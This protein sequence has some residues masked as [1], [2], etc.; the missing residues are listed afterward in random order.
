M[1][2]DDVRKQACRELAERL[3]TP[4][5]LRTA[6]LLQRA[7]LL[8]GAAPEAPEPPPRLPRPSTGWPV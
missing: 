1:K 7:G 3:A 2:D 4:E 6:R 5:G 8:A